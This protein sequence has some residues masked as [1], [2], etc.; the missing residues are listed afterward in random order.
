[1]P[2]RSRWSGRGPPE[3]LVG[4]QVVSVAVRARDGP[5]RTQAVYRLLLQTDPRPGAPAAPG[6]RAEE[7]PDA[8]RPL[9]AGVD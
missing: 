7:A 2:W 6:V 1:M 4:W 3:P 8:D 9:R 5:Q